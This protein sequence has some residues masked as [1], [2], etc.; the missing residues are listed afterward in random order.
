MVHYMTDH[1]YSAQ[2][3]RRDGP[4]TFTDQAFTGRVL[5]DGA[6]FRGCTFQRAVLV[7]SGGA[8]PS[9]QNCTFQGVTFEFAGAAARSLAFLKAMSAPSSGFRDVF[10]ASFPKLFGH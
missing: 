10:K 4:R 2:T 1:G 6:S 3:A 5:L 8:P 9:L 7:Y